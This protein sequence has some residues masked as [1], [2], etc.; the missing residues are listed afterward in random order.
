MF[1]K[2]GKYFSFVI[3]DKSISAIMGKWT[4][5]YQPPNLA[6]VNKQVLLSRNKLPA[7]FGELF[8]ITKEEQTQYDD[9]KDDEAL[10]EIII[11]DAKKE[12]AE[13]IK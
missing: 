9:A 10:K 13:Y 7:W 4:L 2:N 6:E 8:K 12:G 11:R 5:P 3:N 1:K